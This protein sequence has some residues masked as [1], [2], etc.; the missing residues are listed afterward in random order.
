M[1]TICTLQRLVLAGAFTLVTGLATAGEIS[2]P[3]SS[4]DNDD[5]D[6][7]LMVVTGLAIGTS[8]NCASE[9]PLLPGLCRLLGWK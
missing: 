7:V 2:P 1:P 3:S 8:I 5:T 4:D 9:N 6:A